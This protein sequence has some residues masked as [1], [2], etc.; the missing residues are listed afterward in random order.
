MCDDDGSE[1][2]GNPWRPPEDRSLLWVYLGL[3]VVIGSA[4]LMLWAVFA[5]AGMLEAA[6]W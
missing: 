1:D 4:G 6:T 2:F 3:L 5:I